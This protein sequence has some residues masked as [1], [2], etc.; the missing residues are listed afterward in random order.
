MQ[1]DNLFRNLTVNF[2]L[3]T[4]IKQPDM[5]QEN[6]FFKVYSPEKF[7]RRPRDDI[8]LDLKFNIETPQ[9]LDPWVNLLPSFKGL[10]LS[11]E[12]DDWTKNKTKDGTIQ[13]HIL[14]KSFTRA[15]DV[16]KK[17]FIG[18]IFLLGEQQNDIITTKDILK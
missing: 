1:Y 5:V 4:G 13:L 17:Q 3:Y 10:G 18:F 9:T 7:K 8:Y 14:N 16:K 15:I 12:N 6:R 2:S 11:I